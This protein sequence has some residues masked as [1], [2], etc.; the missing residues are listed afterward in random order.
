MSLDATDLFN[1]A[2]GTYGVT[3]FPSNSDI[4]GIGI[5]VSLYVSIALGFTTGFF[6]P[7]DLDSYRDA[8]RTSLVTSTSL[9]ISALYA[10]YTGLGIS[11]ID[12]Q[13]VT[14]F[15]IAITASYYSVIKFDFGFTTRFAARL[16]Q[17]LSAVF[18]ILVYYDVEHFGGAAYLP[19][20]AP[21]DDFK[22]VILSFKVSATNQGLRIFALLLFAAVLA[23]LIWEGRTRF[24][25]GLLK[26]TALLRQDG[27]GKGLLGIAQEISTGTLGGKKREPPKISYLRIGIVAIIY[28]IVTVEQTVSWNHLSSLS[29][30]QWTFGQTI[31]VVML[32][33]QVL[34]LAI[35][36]RRR[37]R[38]EVVR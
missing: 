32:A 4:T 29:I 30:S 18:G 11:L 7:N 33:D 5:R 34:K 14:L 9:I 37:G 28:L 27:I 3:T 38:R 1:C 26:S 22:F 36:S 16:H 19:G 24:T 8:A 31:V 12:A 2:N 25:I 10:R 35:K 13:I 6:F 20:C 23:H 15:I 21:N 17:I